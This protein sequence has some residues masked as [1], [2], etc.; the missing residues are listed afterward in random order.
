[1]STATTPGLHYLQL[2]ELSELPRTRTVSPAEVTPPRLD[3]IAA[4][5]GELAGTSC[6][7]RCER[8]RSRLEVAWAGTG[9]V[10]G[11][12]PCR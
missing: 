10:S 9:T 6:S 3:R 4:L 8:E 2:T 1:M 5:D 7:V 12:E 11:A